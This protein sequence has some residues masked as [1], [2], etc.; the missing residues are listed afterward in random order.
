MTRKNR[1][2]LLVFGL[3]S[4]AVAAGPSFESLVANLKSPQ[5]SVR[6]RAA[7]DLGK[8]RD[9]SAISA[10]ADAVR[11]P[12]VDVRVAV[13]RALAEVRD[14]LGVPASVV[15][16]S[17]SQTRVRQ[18]AVDAIVSIYTRRERPSGAGK[19]LALFSAE[20]PD[21]EPLLAANVDSDVLRGLTERLRDSDPGVRESA[22]QAIG[23]LGGSEAARELTV[24]LVDPSVSVREAAATAV[25]KVGTTADGEAL[26]PL[27]QD[28]SGGVRRKAIEGLGALRVADASPSLRKLFQKNVDSDEGIAALG[29]LARIA[30]AS[31]TPLFQR[32]ALETEPRRRRASIEGLARQGQKGN[33]A[34]FKRDFQREKSDELRAAYAFAIFSFGD[35][36][37]IDTLVMGLAGSRDR[38]L[39]SQSYLA[40]L[41]SRMLPEA[42]DYVREGDPKI[43]GGLAEAFGRARLQESIPALEV[44]V[45]DAE[46]SVVERAARA[47]SLIRRQRP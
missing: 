29:A 12:D 26:I 42:L 32:Y 22:A 13:V 45:K 9:R 38:A 31:D 39:Q 7:Q 40:E 1:L 18:E 28:S 27:L 35:R 33:E 30:E 47:L 8:T 37:F 41:G 4:S 23:I 3:A 46:P 17:D 16:L 43:R 24:A 6:R 10:L 21:P 15:A 44:L 19:F 5:P 11:D 2:L 34:R 25:A 14:V 36:P 20:R